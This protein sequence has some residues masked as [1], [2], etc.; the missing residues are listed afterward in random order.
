MLKKESYKTKKIK[1][2]LHS[3]LAIRYFSIILDSNFF[4]DPQHI[5]KNIKYCV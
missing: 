5:D 3:Q 1:K 4:F 2:S